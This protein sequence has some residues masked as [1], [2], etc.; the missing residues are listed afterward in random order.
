MCPSLWGP[1]GADSRAWA[2]WMEALIEPASQHRANRGTNRGV[3]G[4]G[5]TGAFL[6]LPWSGV[7]GRVGLEPTTYGL[8]VR[9]CRIGPACSV[10][11]GVD[12]SALSPI[13]VPH[14]AAA[15]R[16]GLE[17]TSRHRADT[18]PLTILWLA[19][20]CPCLTSMDGVFG[21][22]RVVAGDVTRLVGARLGHRSGGSPGGARR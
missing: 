3:P 1:R 2:G 10:P 19:R 15:C 9:N 12:P 11:A 7:V 13:R 22:R 5:Q 18:E 6:R 17:P 16:S 8:K 21:K 14:G 4:R 20:R